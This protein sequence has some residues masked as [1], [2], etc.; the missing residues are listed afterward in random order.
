MKRSFSRL[1]G[2]HFGGVTPQ[3]RNVLGIDNI[4]IFN[5][6]ASLR[7]PRHADSDTRY[8]ER[9]EIKFPECVPIARV[10]MGAHPPSGPRLVLVNCDRDV[11]SH[12]SYASDRN[13]RRDARSPS[14][15]SPGSPVSYRVPFE[16]AR[17]VRTFL[18]T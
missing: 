4:G 6:D 8:A 11:R 13:S 2:L 18:E 17:C 9:C 14:M 10:R 12:G 7:F 1:T 5:R 15:S 3:S 16:T